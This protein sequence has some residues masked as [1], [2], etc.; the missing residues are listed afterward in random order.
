MAGLVS[1]PQLQKTVLGGLHLLTCLL[2]ICVDFAC[3][4]A[5]GE[6]PGWTA[7]E[8]GLVKKWAPLELSTA[9]L[10]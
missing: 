6:A 9:A 3:S 4:K 5:H 10:A 2:G 7:L 1:N 8:E